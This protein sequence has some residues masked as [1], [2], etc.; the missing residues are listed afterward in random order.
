MRHFLFLCFL[1]FP[2]FILAQDCEDLKKFLVGESPV[3]F[4][5]ACNDLD[6][7][8]GLECPNDDSSISSRF[9][10]IVVPVR[11]VNI[12]K[13]NGDFSYSTQD[14]IE[15]FRGARDT[16]KKFRIHLRVLE[17][18]EIKDDDMNLFGVDFISESSAGNCDHDTPNLSD[19]ITSWDSQNYTPLNVI[20][21]EGLTLYSNCSSSQPTSEGKTGIADFPNY[22]NIL[23]ISHS[24]H[25]NSSIN[26]SKTLIHELGHSFGLFHTFSN[27]DL[28]QNNGC[29]EGDGITDTPAFAKELFNCKINCNYICPPYNGTGQ[30]YI[31]NYMSYTGNCRKEF[32]DYQKRKMWDIAAGTFPHIPMSVCVAPNKPDLHLANYSTPESTSK[33]TPNT[34]SS[35]Q[36][37]SSPVIISADIITNGGGKH[38]NTENIVNWEVWD[39][40]IGIAIPEYTKLMT[41]NSILLSPSQFVEGKLYKV[42]AYETPPYNRNCYGLVT[43]FYFQVNNSTTNSCLI[44]TNSL[45]TEV[46]DYVN[47]YDD[48]RIK[49]SGASS[50]NYTIRVEEGNGNEFYTKENASPNTNYDIGFDDESGINF[51]LTIWVEE[52]NNPICRTGSKV[53]HSRNY[54]GSAP[55]CDAVTNFT[56]IVNGTNVTYNWTPVSGAYSYTIVESDDGSSI[57]NQHTINLLN[58]T[59]PPYTISYPECDNFYVKIRV[60]CGDSESSYT[61]YIPVNLENQSSCEN[62]ACS[63]PT[64]LQYRGR[65]NNSELHV[66]WDNPD[67]EDYIICLFKNGYELECKYPSSGSTI[68]L[69]TEECVDYK[70]QIKTNCYPNGE[71][72]SVQKSFKLGSC[73]Q[74]DYYTTLQRG[75]LS[76]E[77][78]WIRVTG[79][80]YERQGITNSSIGIAI[81]LSEDI[82]IDNS[83]ML[84]SEKSFSNPSSPHTT[85]LLANMNNFSNVLSDGSYFV[86]IYLDYYDYLEE[87]SELNNA[88]VFL[89]TKVTIGCKIENTHNYNPNTN[90]QLNNSC[91]TCTDGIKNGDETDVDCGGSLCEPCCYNKYY[92]DNDGDNYGDASSF[93]IACEKPIG[94]VSNKLDCDDNDPTIYLTA[95][96]LCDGKDNDCDGETD[97]GVK[98]IFYRDAD[99]D[100]YGNP[101]VSIDNY[102]SPPNGYVSNADDCND[103]NPALNVQVGCTN[104]RYADSLILVDLYNA[105]N[106]FNWTNIW[107]LNQ[108][109]NTW[110]GITLNNDGCIYE[111]KLPNNNLIGNI[112]PSLGNL[113]NLEI[114]SIHTNILFGGIPTSLGNLSNLRYL[115]ASN[116][117]LSGSIP[118]SL[119]NLNSLEGLTLN[120]NIL[121]GNIPSSLSNLSNLKSFTLYNN[122]LSGCFP[123]EFSVFCNIHHTRFNGNSLLP[124][125]G[126]FSRFCNGESQIGAFCD[127]GNTNTTGEVIRENCDCGTPCIPEICDGLDNDCD[128][129]I[130]EDVSTI[131]YNLSA[132]NV[133]ANSAMLNWSPINGVSGYILLYK[134]NYEIDW[135]SIVVASNSQLIQELVA[136][137]T[138]KWKVKTGCSPYSPEQTFITPCPLPRNVTITQV[139]QNDVIIEWDEFGDVSGYYIQTRKQGNTSWKTTWSTT[140]PL[141]ATGLEE[142]TIYELQIKSYCSNLYS[143]EYTAVKAFKTTCSIPE[144]LTRGNISPTSV[145]LSWDNVPNISSYFIAY[146]EASGSWVYLPSTSTNTYDLI[147]LEKNTNYYWSVKAE[148][149]SFASVQ[150]FATPCSIPSNLS[151]ENITETTVELHWDNVGAS[152]YKIYYKKFNGDWNIID[153]SNPPPYSLTN[154]EPNI[155]YSWGILPDCGAGTPVYT[156]MTKSSNRC[157]SNLDINNNPISSDVYSAVNTITS[158]GVINNSSTVSFQAGTSIILKEGFY[159]YQG[160]DFE[161]K[162]IECQSNIQFDFNETKRVATN[163]PT[164]EISFKDAE[165]TTLSIYPNPTGFEVNI[166]YYLNNAQ[167]LSLYLVD[168]SGKV[169]KEVKGKSFVEKGNY[170]ETINLNSI[171][172]RGVYYIIL[173]GEKERLTKKLIVID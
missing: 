166:N 97:E 112:P 29:F 51:E 89:N 10:D 153:I 105:S 20:F 12:G 32:T 117:R 99:N 21:T 74:V 14:I 93:I 40:D 107:N 146:R 106:G 160:S 148:C 67:N 136:G 157:A 57:R 81:V 80:T 141:T 66:T 139:G 69:N 100:T 3:F 76:I 109:I 30:T 129:D 156:F 147:G 5:Y 18:K 155:S 36:T 11:L 62:S 68:F 83:D 121:T 143:S 58:N 130:D 45:E 13:S 54:H 170:L 149:S 110:H 145:T 85:D 96:E 152:S 138:Y 17:I 118:A 173:A 22:G 103:N 131:P 133:K 127:D 126:N 102:C 154:L 35:P 114:L 77:D 28:G 163:Y 88:T 46:I 15:L 111:I 39:E 41:T 48:I 137:V 75:T 123:S 16:F 4:D 49:F 171:I 78:N 124:W 164:T 172:P 44:N 73:G 159:A 65:Y 92:L 161:A 104:C 59:A 125:E 169:M 82:N 162:I 115:Y 50:T 37:I 84:L 1:I 98:K 108:P 31:K 56:A 151:A 167:Y 134:K 94:R 168:I 86:G 165:K 158:S 7:S 27:Y 23:I 60:F 122:N 128:G 140:S 52:T 90:V 135:T 19:I 34:S 38:S 64:N 9:G 142:N 71:S 2:K 113:N 120:D 144:N 132:S 150:G 8:Y 24:S 63:A 55:T 25:N 79:F 87:V 26:R 6:I 42:K 101:N 119:G 91:Y 61:S 53:I 70:I 47:A 95:P 116:N 33:I 43:E 72:T